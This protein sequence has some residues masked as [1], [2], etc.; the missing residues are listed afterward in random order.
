MPVADMGRTADASSLSVGSADAFEAPD[1][2]LRFEVRLDPASGGDVT[3]DFTTRDGTATLSERDYVETSG[4]LTF[5][6]GETATTVEVPVLADNHDEGAETV[7]LVLSN[8]SSAVIARGERDGCMEA[9]R[10]CEAVDL[11][12]VVEHVDWGGYASTDGEGARAVPRR[13]QYRG[14]RSCRS[15]NARRSSGTMAM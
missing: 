5:E 3:V 12:Q 9:L 1:A 6:A 15:A 2:T 14:G 11:V 8:P 13:F 10:V 4:T 7:W